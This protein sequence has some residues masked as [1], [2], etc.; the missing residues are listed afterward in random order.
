MAVLRLAAWDT[1]AT[2][3]IGLNMWKRPIGLP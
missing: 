1:G 3:Q 2:V